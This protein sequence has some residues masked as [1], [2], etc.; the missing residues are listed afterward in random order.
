MKTAVLVHSPEFACSEN[1]V[2]AF[3]AWGEAYLISVQP[4]D[5]REY[6]A[7][8]VIDNPQALEQ[9]RD[10]AAAADL[11]VI[12]DAISFDCL[13]Q[14]GG[15]NWIRWAYDRRVI[16]FFGDTAYWRFPRYYEGLCN[17]IGLRRIFLLPDLMPLA[18]MP[19][20]P[21]HHPQRLLEGEKA[22]KLTIIH[23]P[24]RDG[25]AVK[26]GTPAI[27][28]VIAKLQE[29]YEFDYK[30]LMYLPLAE[31]L[32]VKATGHIM[33]DQVPPP[34]APFGLGR[35]GLEGMAAGLATITALYDP[36]CL[37]GFFA[38]PPVLP[39]H[40]KIELESMLVKLLESPAIL[41]EAG[42]AA[43]QWVNDT[44]EIEPWLNY[45]CRY[46]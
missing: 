21:L 25:K 41:E 34:G 19:A 29:A 32:R 39:A 4:G 38:P 23:S 31:C 24:G 36:A 43:R 8:L 45:L 28:E 1:L 5:W 40:D 14:I 16:A 6:D 27:E 9:A 35:S 26:K 15:S 22:E 2:R 10:I 20:V 18:G 11:L 12:G 13:G 33:I 30:R 46:L 42:R 3:A 37:E 7:G 44:L 17:A